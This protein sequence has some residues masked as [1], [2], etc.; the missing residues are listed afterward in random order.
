MKRIAIVG[1]GISGLSAAFYLDKHRQQGANV[2]VTLFE[3][4]ARVG[5]VLVSENVDGCVVEGGPDSFLTEKP[6][7][8]ELC[9]ELDLELV[10][11]NDERRQTYI[12]H[13]CR[14]VELPQGIMFTVPTRLLALTRSPLF[15]WKTKLQAIRELFMRPRRNS[16]DLT[17]ADFLRRHYGRE[18]VDRV[19]DP[20]LAGIY[21][22]SADQLSAHAVLPRLVELEA[23]YGSLTRAMWARRN[24]DTGVRLPIFT[25]LRDGMQVLV[26]AIV[27][28]LPPRL[29]QTNNRVESLSR[30]GAGWRLLVN[31]SWRQFDAVVLAI[32]AWAAANLLHSS[33]STLAGELH[34]IPY[35]SSVTVTLG[36][37]RSDLET[38]PSAFGFLVPSDADRALLA[39]TFAHHKFPQRFAADRGAIRA[40]LGGTRAPQVLEWSDE[41][42]L[43]EAK[44]EL[45]EIL[46]VHAEPRFVRIFRWP[47]AMPQYVVG[48]L[49][50]VNR[51]ERLRRELPGL[52][53]IG[54][55][56]RGIGVSDCVRSGLEAAEEIDRMIHSGDP[57]AR[58]QKIANSEEC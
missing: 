42:I 58:S 12:L 47:N 23:Q 49:G 25:A 21:G 10:G 54:N 4:A 35:S 38:L 19:A 36:Y 6:W 51:I 7:A 37:L 45:R 55:A 30:E 50:I 16:A 13:N 32:P 2:E 33:A 14:L 27:R 8:D 1:G 41:Q 18:L 34:S 11:S 43:S 17:A 9:R 5:G 46:E 39:C 48:H 40:F 57:D 15:S 52:V 28:R 20:L 53:L 24:R 3:A 29:I 31:N 56:Y 26:N 22:G 44:R